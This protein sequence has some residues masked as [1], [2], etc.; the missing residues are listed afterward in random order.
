M[1]CVSALTLAQ[2]NWNY[3]GCAFI[4]ICVHNT[5][6]VKA[7]G[8]SDA[9]RERWILIRMCKGGIPILFLVNKGAFKALSLDVVIHSNSFTGSAFVY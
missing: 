6:C 3:L 4:W 2:V 9:S 1:V 7:F 8:L 5:S